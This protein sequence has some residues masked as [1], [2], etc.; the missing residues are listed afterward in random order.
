M[1]MMKRA[2]EL[3]RFVAFPTSVHMKRRYRVM[4]Y[5][6][7]TMKIGNYIETSFTWGGISQTTEFVILGRSDAEYASDPET[8]RSVSGG[9]VFLCDSVIFAFL[10]CRS[11]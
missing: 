3:S 6:R 11:V 2:R 4:N 1:Q 8:R 5:V 7:E 9:T 10:A